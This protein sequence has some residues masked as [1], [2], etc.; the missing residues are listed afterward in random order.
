MG[1]SDL[2]VLIVVTLAEVGG[3]QMSVLNLARELKRRGLDVTLGFGRGDFLHKECLKFKIPTKRFEHL[4]RSWSVRDNIRFVIELRK[5]LKENKFDVLHMNSSNTLFGAISAYL[6]RRRPAT[7]F[8]YRGMSFLDDRHETSRSKRL[9]YRTV[10]RFLTFFVD[11]EIFV[12]KENLK[13]AKKMG[14]GRKGVVI[15]NGLSMME[16]SFMER[17]NARDELELACG[18]L[19]KDKIVVGSIGRLAYQ[20]NYEFLIKN[21]RT[22][23]EEVPEAICAV[24]GEGPDRRKLEK[25]IQKEGISESFFLA[26]EYPNAVKLLKGFDVF[27]L[28]SRYEG[29]S[30]TTLE[31]L[32]AGVPM[33]ISKTGGNSEVV[34]GFGPFLF[35]VNDGEEFNK[36][37]IKL[38]TGKRW[39]DK[40]EAVSRKESYRFSIASTA[41]GYEAIYKNGK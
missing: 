9:F 30:I 4:S 37:M 2:K 27:V 11:K 13:S 35:N 28:P 19:L 17:G 16:L 10:F 12:S 5:Y 34:G 1:N 33:L 31:A 38:L 18:T 24:L 22:I 14:L 41:N 21:W 23:K 26:G 15:Y 39:N 8:T 3:A 36:K 20:K 7:F 29:L 6:L 32:F 40:A 25:M